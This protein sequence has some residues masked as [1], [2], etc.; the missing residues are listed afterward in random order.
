[1]VL[2]ESCAKSLLWHERGAAEKAL[3]PGGCIFEC[4]GSP[5][6]S[7]RAYEDTAADLCGNRSSGLADQGVAGGGGHDRAFVSARYAFHVRGEHRTGGL[8]ASDG[9]VSVADDAAARLSGFVAE[10]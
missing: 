7:R 6:D 2:S 3:S 5:G 4:H 8:S 9:R 10:R 1:M